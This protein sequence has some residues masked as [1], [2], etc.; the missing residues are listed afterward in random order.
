[1]GLFYRYKIINIAYS[2]IKAEIIRYKDFY[3][4]N[5]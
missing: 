2:I 5:N 1:M 3:N 4:K